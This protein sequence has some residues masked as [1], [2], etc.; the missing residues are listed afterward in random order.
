[1][2]DQIHQTQPVLAT[3]APLDQARLGVILLHGRGSTAEDI[4]PLAGALD[5]RDCTFLIPQAALNR[6][7]PNSA[8]API[9]SNQPDLSS[10]LTRIDQL[11]EDLRQ[12]GF[13]YDRIAIGGFSQGACLASE[14][15]AR[16]AR[17]YAGLFA[18]TGALIGPPGTERRYSGSFDG[19]PVFIGGSDVDPWVAHNLMA[20]TAAVF[21][22]MG[23]AVDFRT[24]PGMAHTV[25]QDEL[26]AVREL[27]AAADRDPADR[28]QA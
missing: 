24:Y 22:H 6:W 3:G 4:A 13:T 12:Q 16:R 27:L 21:E 26:D 11:V 2:G 23:A 14:Y 9:E 10:A 25:N 20:K 17:R 8:F 15:V 7:Y 1:M 28:D 19:M 5:L 18:L